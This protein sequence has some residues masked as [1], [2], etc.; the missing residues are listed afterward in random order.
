MWKRGYGGGSKRLSL[1]VRVIGATST[2]IDRNGVGCSEGGTRV[3]EAAKN[4]GLLS[5]SP[6]AA[7][8]GTFNK[9]FD[10]WRGGR[11]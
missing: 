4:K 11:R 10:K 9:T 5:H 7:K 3:G 2:M 8:R 1:G 6:E